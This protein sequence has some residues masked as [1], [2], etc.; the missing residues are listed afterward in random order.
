MQTLVYFLVWGAFIFFMMRFGCGAHVMGHVHSRRHD[1]EKPNASITVGG[2]SWTPPAKNIDPVC[3]MTV[4]TA[5]AKSTV[6]DG[7]VYYFCSQNCREKFEASPQSYA[8]G[9][10]S[11]LLNMEHSIEHQH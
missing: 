9:A 2:A 1:G 8:G 6:H 3:G 10:A 4:E 11:S 5:G 7:R